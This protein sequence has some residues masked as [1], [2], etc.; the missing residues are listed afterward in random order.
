MNSIVQGKVLA[1]H[2]KFPGIKEELTLSTTFLTSYLREHIHLPCCFCSNRQGLQLVSTFTCLISSSDNLLNSSLKSV[3][4]AE[5][6]VSETILGVVFIK[7]THHTTYS[8]RQNK[9]STVWFRKT[10]DSFTVFDSN[11]VLF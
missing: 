11:I 9:G 5:A 8:T 4:K 7:R 2:S 1:N 10:C 6:L 3:K